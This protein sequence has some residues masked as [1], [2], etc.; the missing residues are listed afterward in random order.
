MRLW[1]TEHTIADSMRN[2]SFQATGHAMGQV[3]R[4]EASG[5]PQL[6]TLDSAQTSWAAASAALPI[7]DSRRRRS[8]RSGVIVAV[9]GGRPR[10]HD[11][12]VTV[13]DMRMREGQKLLT[14][15]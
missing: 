14:A 3:L 9:P 5:P 12:H 13:V 10:R 6:G 7:L 4:S 15:R 11:G 2:M 8:A 1:S